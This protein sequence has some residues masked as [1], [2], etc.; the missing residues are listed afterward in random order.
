MI[1]IESVLCE[2]RENPIGIDVSRPRISYTLK[3][4]NRGMFQTACQIQIAEEENFSNTIADSGVIESSNSI[5]IGL[6]KFQMKPHTRYY[7]RIKVWSGSEESEWS[8]T[9][10]F[11]TGFLTSSWQAKW[12]KGSL[13]NPNQSPQF[14]KT[15]N[16]IENKIQT[17]RLYITATGLYEAKING[18]RVGD[19]Y[20]TPG[21]TNYND[22]IQYQVYD[23]KEML[24]NQENVLSVTL[25]KGWY[26]GNLGWE[27]KKEIYG[28]E[29]SFIAELHLTYSNGEEVIICSDT[30]WYYT[31]SPILQSEIY[32]GEIYDARLCQEKWDD[33]AFCESSWNS[34]LEAS[35]PRGRIV[36]QENEPVRKQE[37]IQPIELIN[38]P[39]GECVLDFGQNL[40]GWVQFRVKGQK[41][42]TVTLKHFEVLDKDG[43]VYLENLRSAKQTV[44]YTLKGSDYEYYEPYFTF[45]GFR[46]VELIGF[47]KDIS[48][49]DFT[50]VVLHS[51]MRRTGTFY[52]SDERINQ[53]Q[54]NIVW[55]QK[56]NFVDVPTDCPQRDER[57]GWTGDAQ[58]FIS[59]ASFLYNVVPFF[60]KWLR[61]LASEQ[62]KDGRV[63]YVIP[64][65]LDDDSHSSAAWGDAAVICPWVIYQNYADKRLLE[66]QYPSMK[67][68]VNY[69]Q[70]QGDDPFLWNTGFH[71]GDWLALDAQS[72]SYI[73]STERDFIATAFY[74]YS[75]K[76]VSKAAY[77]LDKKEDGI[78]YE[79]LYQSIK[80]AFNA[81]FVTANGRL[82]VPT[83]TAHILAL[84]FDLVDNSTK[85]RTIKKLE[86]LLADADYHLKTGFVGT[87]YLNFVL[88]KCEMDHIASK[89]LFQLDYPSW[90]YQVEK[91]ATTIW[92]HWDGIKEDGDFWSSD[93][94][95]FNHYA[96][97]AIGD[98]LYRKVA[99][100]DCNEEKPGFQQIE[101]KPHFINGLQF[102]EASLDTMYG[103]TSS[104]WRI[105]KDKEMIWEVTVPFNTSARLHFSL[106]P[107]L[108]NENNQPITMGNGI[109]V[110]QEERN[111]TIVTVGSGKYE[112][113][114]QLPE[115][116]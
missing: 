87:P 31:K 60:T 59:T 95:S 56:G 53:L 32:H 94:N 64:Q 84:M 30:S 89:L 76:L 111:E 40:V 34:A 5:H 108:I 8:N 27:G 67:A 54:H 1:I 48:L 39:N 92:E 61:D 29:M 96:Y 10:F 79:N 88:S 65:V 50:A 37:K 112:F 33:P 73:G 58:M 110:I 115:I 113:H 102:V 100:I 6:P 69:I 18:N 21:W 106:N 103:Q 68:W 38:T 17:A 116:S 35:K 26:L 19:F 98:W 36:A 44:S 3:G 45:Q 2:Y 90:L 99:G 55:G 47:D 11:E 75:T 14:R 62:G 78:K 63:P 71:F 107:E 72:G 85:D 24:E 41:G 23:V 80:R 42:V 9:H 15:F 20:L 81:E 25:G 49:E 105:I 93:M 114:L 104:K 77:E 101:L 43:N 109:Q 22:R 12:I 74:A 57:M 86:Q 46:Y 70:E 91:G 13:E 66:E 83:Q 97:G 28:Q 7:Y 16:L 82:A 52:C 4:N 51:D